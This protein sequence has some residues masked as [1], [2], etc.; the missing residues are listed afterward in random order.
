ML[1]LFIILEMHVVVLT[2]LWY[3]IFMWCLRENA[4]VCY[5]LDYRSHDLNPG[6]SVFLTIFIYDSFI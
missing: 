5:A 3:L 4:L 6:K 1:L 2:Q